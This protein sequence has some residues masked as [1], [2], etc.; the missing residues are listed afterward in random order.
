MNRST[1]LVGSWA[2]SSSVCLISTLA[3]WQGLHRV[4]NTAPHPPP[5]LPRILSEHSCHPRPPNRQEPLKGL[6]EDA[7]FPT[8][9]GCLWIVLCFYWG[10]KRNS[11][12]NERRQND[13]TGRLSSYPRSSGR[14]LTGSPGSRAAGPSMLR[15]HLFSTDEK[16]K[17][18]L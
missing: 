17:H 7:L 9:H 15:C 2:S 10:L 5:L 3:S 11:I 12:R 13:C 16:P 1:A 14:P 6:P 8:R 4:I 18:K